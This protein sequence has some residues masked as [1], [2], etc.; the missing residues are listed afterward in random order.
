MPGIK[1]YPI[2]SHSSGPVFRRQVN[3]ISA[4]QPFIA[5]VPE[6]TRY[7][8][9]AESVEPWVFSWINFYGE[10]AIRLWSVLREQSRSVF[11]LPVPTLHL[12]E[13]LIRRYDERSYEDRYDASL[14]S[15][16]FYLDVARRLET[17]R[18]PTSPV[19]ASIDF[20]RSHLREPIRVKE[21]AAYA[22]TS[23]EYLSRLFLRETGRSPGVYLRV[24]RLE[25]AV[26]LLCSTALPASEIALRSGFSSPAKLSH[27]FRRH[28][29][30]S[31][32]AFRKG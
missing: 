20:M 23:R 6:N 19:E 12:L 21:I 18:K 27:F 16:R 30:I 11:V 4:G 2:S 7:Y 22:G 17:S 24:L 5:V 13:D 31:P 1:R 25:A 10:L 8:Y 29:R 32:L 9:S 14:S 26:R 28:Y 15:Y 3:V